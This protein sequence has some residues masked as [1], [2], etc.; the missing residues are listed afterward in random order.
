MCFSYA[1]TTTVSGIGEY[2]NNNVFAKIL[3]KKIPA[4]I[5]FE[6]KHVLAFEDIHPIKP[7]HILIIPKGKYRS[8]I[9][10]SNNATEIEI[11][12]LIR[13]MGK[14]ADI[15]GITQSGFSMITNSGHHG[16]QTVPHLHFHLL[17]GEPVHWE[18]ALRDKKTTK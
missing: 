13:A 1:G 11:T 15:M 16:G 5:I 8:L 18:T 6:N 14:I 7:V 2:D 3:A 4:T 9:D 10:F 12:A 17:G